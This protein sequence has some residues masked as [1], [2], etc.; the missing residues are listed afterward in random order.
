M[1]FLRR[2]ES[3]KPLDIH[4]MALAFLQDRMQFFQNGP[5]VAG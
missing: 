3:A 2:F 5:D 1:R 4:R